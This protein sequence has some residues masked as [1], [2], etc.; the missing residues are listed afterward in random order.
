MTDMHEPPAYPAS[1]LEWEEP[2]AQ[3]DEEDD[4]AE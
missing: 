4:D 3:E 1:S 2:E